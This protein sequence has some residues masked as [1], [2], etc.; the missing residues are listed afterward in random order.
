MFTFHLLLAF[1][2]RFGNYK[3]AT[4]GNTYVHELVHFVASHSLTTVNKVSGRVA[5]KQA[6]VTIIH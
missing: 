1:E 5:L 6:H 3:N 4:F 2:L